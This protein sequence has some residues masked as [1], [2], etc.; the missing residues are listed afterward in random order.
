MK[1]KAIK[2]TPASITV[3]LSDGTEHIRDGWH[4]SGSAPVGH[5]SEGKY[6][7][8]KYGLIKL[9]GKDTDFIDPAK[10]RLWALIDLKAGCIIYYAEVMWAI[11]LYLGGQFWRYVD[12][13]RTMKD[14]QKTKGR[15]SVLIKA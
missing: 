10:Q 15:Y 2:R 8:G 1:Q 11:Q 14:V 12:Y 4:V 6:E 7:S 13:L 5:E 3:R 9:E